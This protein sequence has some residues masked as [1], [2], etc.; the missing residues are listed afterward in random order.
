MKV[1]YTLDSLNR[2]GTETLVLDVCRN[3]K[4]F[5]LDLTFV[6]TGGGDLE[7]EF[8][9][10][11]ANY[12]RLNREFPLDPNLVWKLRQ[13]I[14]ENKIEI[15]HCHQPVESFHFYLATLGLKNVKCVQT[16]HGGGL[17]LS[18]NKNRLM[19]K[20]ITP[21]MDANIA[22]SRGLFPWLR[23][24]IGV[25]T[26]KN[27]YLVYNGVDPKRLEPHGDSLKKELGFDENSFLLGMVANFM[28]TKTKDQM[29]VCRALPKVFE[30]FE[31]ANFVFVGGIA[32]DGEEY[33]DEC[34]KFCDE[35]GI[36][37]K[38]FFLGKRDDIPNVLNSL[39]IFVFSTLHEGLP[40]ALIEA[41]LAKVPVISTDIAPNLEATDNGKCVE[42]FKPKNAQ[43]LSDKILKLL[44]DKDLRNNLAEDA[45][46][47]AQQNF[48]IEAHFRALKT[49]Y[50]DLLKSMETTDKQDENPHDSE[51]TKKSDSIFGL[52]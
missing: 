46:N 29:T 14:K 40:I 30:E 5:G 10:S 22:C 9:N 8:K 2:G 34:I 45:Y 32:E 7:D 49:L 11:G 35:N 28:S 37:E 41:M 12:I 51:D 43:E 44:K 24:E 39:D 15:I 27:F 36:G 47:H 6:A 42:T 19:A 38:V 16:H 18:N 31:N 50:F 1:L 23:K 26:S 4:R 33:F 21:R 3:A 52:D 20:F 17:F 25:D 48:S 13:I